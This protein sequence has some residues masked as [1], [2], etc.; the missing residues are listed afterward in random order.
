MIRRRGS[1]GDMNEL[2]GGWGR[3]AGRT[4][5]QEGRRPREEVVH[6]SPWMGLSTLGG[7]W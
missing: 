1:A 7:G 4:D 3:E 5:R 6:D 2:K